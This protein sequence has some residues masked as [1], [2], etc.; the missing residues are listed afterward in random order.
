MNIQINKISF[1]YFLLQNVHL[2]IFNTAVMLLLI[3]VC[4]IAALKKIKMNFFMNMDYYLSTLT[5]WS[6]PPLAPVEKKNSGAVPGHK[7]YGSFTGGEC[8][9]HIE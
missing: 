1:I 2:F 6:S 4:T 8:S 5:Y 3:V 9:K 7:N